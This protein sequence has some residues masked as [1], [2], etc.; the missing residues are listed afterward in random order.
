M[1]L[2]FF[3][4]DTGFGGNNGLTDFKRLLG[5]S[6][7]DPQTKLGLYIISGFVL[8]L[9]YLICRYITTS[10]L[11]RVL[12]AIREA[13]GRVRFSGY[14]SLHYKLFIWTLSAVLCGIAGALYVPQV[15]IINPSE[16]Q[17]ANS[18]EM[19]IWVAV[20][21]RGTLVGAV[22]GA[23]LVNGAKSWFTVAYPDLWLYLLGC[24]FIATTLFL[25]KGVIGFGD[26]FKKRLRKNRTETDNSNNG[27]KD[28]SYVSE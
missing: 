28:Y 24:M 20:G 4:N 19:A 18:I 12:T 5:F 11:G 17:P 8:L 1:M 9:N 6:L 7:Q 3:R 14:K 13:E 21:G 27:G 25:P 2:V 23:F 16:M 26:F 10:K 15:G 22:A